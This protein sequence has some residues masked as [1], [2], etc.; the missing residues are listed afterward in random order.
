LSA[1]CNENTFVN[2]TTSEPA[3]LRRTFLS[4]ELGNN[5]NDP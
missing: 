1:S 2:L 5:V 3:V 4:P